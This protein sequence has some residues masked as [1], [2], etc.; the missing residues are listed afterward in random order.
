MLKR[1][2]RLSTLLR[3][4]FIF[5]FCLL[6]LWRCGQTRSSRL[7]LLSTTHFENSRLSICDGNLSAISLIQVKF[8]N[9]WQL[10]QW[11]LHTGLSFRF[12]YNFAVILV[13]TKIF[14]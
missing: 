2:V 14:L 7:I 6:R 11:L 9:P 5:I 3:A 8:R 1:L 10:L 4:L 12:T 13:M